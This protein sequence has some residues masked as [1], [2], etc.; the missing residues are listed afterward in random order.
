M[1]AFRLQT[2]TLFVVPLI[3]FGLGCSGS[4]SKE[5]PTAIGLSTVSMSTSPGDGATATFTA[6]FSDQ[7]GAGNITSAGVLIN[8]AADGVKSCYVISLPTQNTLSLVRDS[9]TGSDVLQLGKGGTVSNSQCSLYDS[10][11]SV[12]MA[13]NDLTLILKV[14]FKDSYKGSKKIFMYAENKDGLKKGLQ[15]PVA[16]WV[17]K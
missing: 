9:G 17:V 4:G 12:T 10:G 16:T 5:E 7:K 15:E 3:I 2:L 1:R 6:K 14:G 8:T 11:S 13:G